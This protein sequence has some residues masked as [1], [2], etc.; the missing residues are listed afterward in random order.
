MRLIVRGKVEALQKRTMA[1]MKADKLLGEFVG[2]NCQTFAIETVSYYGDGRLTSWRADGPITRLLQKGALPQLEVV[3]QFRLSNVKYI[4]A[5]LMG[6]EGEQCCLQQ[7]RA[8]AAALKDR[9]EAGLG[10]PEDCDL[11]F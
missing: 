10:R 8:K 4:P 5:H 3:I 9:S 6:S 11:E 2:I 7:L 1:M